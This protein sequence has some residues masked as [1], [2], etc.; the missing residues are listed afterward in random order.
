[1]NLRAVNFVNYDG[2]PNES[3]NTVFTNN[4]FYAEPGLDVTFNFARLESAIFNNNVFYNVPVPV[5][6]KG[7]IKVE[8]SITDK[9]IL[10]DVGATGNG[11]EKI[12][13]KYKPKS[14]FVLTKGVAVK[15]SGGKDLLGKN[16]DNKLIGALAK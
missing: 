13:A 7:R 10:V 9:P 4:I 5:D 11:L 12:A 16:V 2:G 15:N 3:K 1:K 6:A 8:N 14:G